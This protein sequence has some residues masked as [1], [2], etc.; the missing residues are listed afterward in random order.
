L[1]AGIPA[2]QI[3][4]AVDRIARISPVRRKMQAFNIE[5][6]KKKKGE[7]EQNGE[8]TFAR[9]VKAVL[10]KVRYIPLRNVSDWGS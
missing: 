2:D 6:K 8:L 1:I 3:G 10:I 4:R 9:S 7:I 5:K